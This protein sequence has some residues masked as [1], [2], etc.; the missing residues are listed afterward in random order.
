MDK[1]KKEKPVFCWYYTEPVP[2]YVFLNNDVVFVCVG[3]D[4]ST[5]D[6]LGPL[7]GDML[8]AKGIP[9]VYGTIDQPVH[10]MN[11]EEVLDVVARNHPEACVIGID[12]CLGNVKNVGQIAFWDKALEPGTGVGKD[13]PPVGQYAITGV[14]NVRGFNEYKVL[15]TTRLSLVWSLAESIVSFIEQAFPHV[16]PDMVATTSEAQMFFSKRVSK[17]KQGGYYMTKQEFLEKYGDQELLEI[18]FCVYDLVDALPEDFEIA[19]DDI[20]MFLRG[21]S[22]GMESG[23]MEDWTLI[24]ETAVETAVAMSNMKRT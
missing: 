13:L 21:V 16:V 9:N 24:A 14:V 17:P 22:K 18:K 8:Q 11:I 12:A 19:E 6:C 20:P 2:D 3:T 23:M 15:S 5:G 4:R 7:I 10:A 1:K